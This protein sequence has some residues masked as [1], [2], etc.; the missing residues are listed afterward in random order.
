MLGRNGILV[1]RHQNV[2][3][4]PGDMDVSMKTCTIVLELLTVL[5]TDAASS[6]G[7]D[8]RV[9]GR[10]EG[11][12]GKHVVQLVSADFKG[13]SKFVSYLKLCLYHVHDVWRRDLEIPRE[14][15]LNVTIINQWS[16][17]FKIQYHPYRRY[18]ET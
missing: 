8:P 4:S 18:R 15:A 12:S 17:C 5:C 7:G 10:L 3:P 14:L 1:H 6:T 11:I 2:K 13:A 9:P 16:R